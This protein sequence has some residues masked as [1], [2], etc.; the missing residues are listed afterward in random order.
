MIVCHGCHKEITGPY[1]EALGHSWHKQH[2]VCTVCREEFPDNKF[3]ERDGK[4]Y[5]DRDYYDKFGERCHGC[6]KPITNHYI[7]ALGHK[8]HKDHFVCTICGKPFEDAGFLQRDGKPYCERD[9]Y[10]LFGLKCNV[11]HEPLRGEYF[12]DSWD[13]SFCAR[14]GDE[15]QQCFTCRRLICES[16][17][18]GGVEYEDGRKMCNVCRMT[19]IDKIEAALPL[20]AQVQSILAKQGLSL[21]D[22]IRM[23]LRLASEDEIDNLAGGTPQIEA[24]L[25]LME[26][27]TLNGLETGRNVKE[28]VILYGLPST[29]AAAVLAHEFGHV[30]CFL[31]DLPHLP[32]HELEGICE[33]FSYE[34]L[35]SIDTPESRFH[36]KGIESNQDP[37]YGGG[38][39][40]IRDAIN[41]RTLLAFL[42]D[43][44]KRGNLC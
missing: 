28:V 43:I 24:G 44:N 38:F 30:W 1:I 7:E 42:N 39:R 36:R 27:L 21:D 22:S 9:F 15:L 13:N 20:F 12:R 4:P 18:G 14:H 8:W 33:M 19:A 5:C 17:T 37:V 26:T 32:I 11:C 29:H 23:P 3:Q 6:G 35:L 16:I 25:S 41:G 31:N 2:F 34:Y 10:E 40:Q